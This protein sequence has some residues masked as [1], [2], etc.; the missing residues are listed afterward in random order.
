N[1]LTAIH[2]IIKHRGVPGTLRS[3]SR[4]D[5]EQKRSWWVQNRHCGARGCYLRPD[6]YAGTCGRQ[7]IPD[8]KTLVPAP[9]RERKIRGGAKTVDITD[10]GNYF[11]F[12]TFGLE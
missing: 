1:F 9:R 12:K 8:P 2:A 5:T 7:A 3:D 10:S 6:L 11:D 4:Q